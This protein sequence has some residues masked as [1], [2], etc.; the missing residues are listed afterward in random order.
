MSIY[1]NFEKYWAI[2]SLLTYSSP[3]IVTILCVCMCAEHLGYNLFSEF[4]VYNAIL[5]KTATLFYI[6]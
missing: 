2:S 6:R 5:L 4:Q 1:K 3:H